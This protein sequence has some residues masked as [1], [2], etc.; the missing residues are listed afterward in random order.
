MAGRPRPQA[1]ATLTPTWYVSAYLKWGGTYHYDYIRF[2]DRNQTFDAHLACLRIGTALNAKL[3][4]NA[5]LQYNSAAA[6]FLAN[7]R[8]RYTLQ[9]SRGQRPVDRLQQRPQHGRRP[10]P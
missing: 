6:A 1:S 8:S 3:S 2:P 7:L 4:T 9:L 5:F 10:L